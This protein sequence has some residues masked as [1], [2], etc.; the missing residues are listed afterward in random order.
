MERSQKV[1]RTPK[2]LK[3]QYEP[4]H[5]ESQRPLCVSSCVGKGGVICNH[6]FPTPT[7]QLSFSFG[8]VLLSEVM[9]RGAV[10]GTWG[11]ENHLGV[12]HR[13]KGDKYV[14]KSKAPSSNGWSS[15]WFGK[16]KAFLGRIVLVLEV[17]SRKRKEPAFTSRHNGPPT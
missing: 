15:C 2:I 9:R 6:F 17:E 11:E 7:C 10:L 14:Y 8:E 4:W 3:M 1:S 16:C 13:T 5:K 12:A